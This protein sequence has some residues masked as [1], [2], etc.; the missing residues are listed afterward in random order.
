MVMMVK[1]VMMAAALSA[2]V[3]LLLPGFYQ[4]LWL[5]LISP[6]GRNSR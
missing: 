5:A 6:T 2:W 3:S 1:M 4:E